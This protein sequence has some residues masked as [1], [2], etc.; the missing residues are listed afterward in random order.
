MENRIDIFEEKK[1]LNISLVANKS[2]KLTTEE[3]ISRLCGVKWD[4][5]SKP[6]KNKGERGQLLEL[7]LGIQNS[8][9]LIDMIDGELKTYTIGETICITQLK[10]CLD[11]IIK[12]LKNF[13]ESALGIKLQ[14]TLYV[15]FEKDG[16]YKGSI[17]I[18]NATDPIHFKKMKED[19]NHICDSIRKTFSEK[20]TLNTIT[21]PNKLLQIRTKASRGSKGEYT[22]L[23]YEGHIL[24]NKYMAFYL[25]SSFGKTILE[26]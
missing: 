16:A 5:L 23:L 2:N 26:K 18:N 11:E 17:L 1:N 22:P 8:C 7:A 15:G 20:N 4:E 6:G 14:Q 9:S 13:E 24:K 21:G 25:C 12:S 10:H 3:V 19:Y